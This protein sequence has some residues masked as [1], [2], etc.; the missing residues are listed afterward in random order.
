M[1]FLAVG[2]KH[3]PD[4][5]YRLT[6][7]RIGGVGVDAGGA[8]LGVTQ[9]PLYDVHVRAR[10]LVPTTSGLPSHGG[11]Y[12]RRAMGATPAPADL[13]GAAQGHVSLTE[14]QGRTSRHEDAQDPHVS[15][16]C[17]GADRDGR[18]RG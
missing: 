13:A 10:A 18:V 4:A 15:G 1:R 8:D 7:Q 11:T 12:A 14:R 2:P 16:M 17:F 5:V 6:R 3:A 9:N